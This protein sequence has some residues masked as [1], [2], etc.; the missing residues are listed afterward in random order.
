MPNSIVR[1]A[2][3]KVPLEIRIARYLKRAESGCLVWTGGR[4]PSGYGRVWDGEKQIYA[5][6][7]VWSLHNGLIPDGMQVDHLCHN[8]SCCEIT[9]LRLTSHGENQQNRKGA[10]ANSTTGYRGVYFTRGKYEARAQ[11]DN[12]V[13][14]GGRYLTAEEAN[15]AAIRLRQEHHIAG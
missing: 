9:H 5:H 12:R 10:Q 11:A 4:I 13:F 14:R 1:K 3:A 6:R 15:E 2:A 7:A 8:H